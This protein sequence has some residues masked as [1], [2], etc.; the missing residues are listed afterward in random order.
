VRDGDGYRCQAKVALAGTNP[1]ASATAAAGS[2]SFNVTPRAGTNRLLLVAIVSD[3]LRSNAVSAGIAGSRP[4]SVKFGSQTLSAGPS[5]VG[6]SDAY[7]PDLFVYYLPLGDAA[8]DGAST[9]ISISGSSGPANVVVAQSLLLNGVRQSMPITSFA[10][11][12][13]GE[14]DPDDP[15]VVAPSLPVAVSGS[16]IYSF[17][18]D[19][20]DTRSCALGARSSGCPAWSATP[21]AN[22]TLTET[23]ATEP[24]TFY[25][26]NSG[27]APMR[28]FGM[29]VTGASPSS[30]AVG[31]YAPSWSDPNPGRLT[32]LAVVL[33]PAQAAPAALRLADER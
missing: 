18:A 12:S 31:T 33:A 22:L 6:A 27:S 5:Q 3:A 8:A 26:P 14:P 25:P 17:I 10:G 23:L 15:G 7:S 16:L 30:P 1:T 24:L 29:V 19:Y 9:A 13:V 4:G 2:L 20:W 11:G 32:H 28:A 21:A